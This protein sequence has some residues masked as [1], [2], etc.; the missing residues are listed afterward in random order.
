MEDLANP[1]ATLAALVLIVFVAPFL[2]ILFL[3]WWIDFYTKV[4]KRIQ[5]RRYAKRIIDTAV[6]RFVEHY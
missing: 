5:Q 4:T 2:T 3:M 6:T 1:V